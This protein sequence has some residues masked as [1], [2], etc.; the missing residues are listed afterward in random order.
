MIQNP[1]KYLITAG[2]KICC[3]RCKAQSSRTKLQC[4]KPALKGKV[5]C[6]FH[7]GLSTGPKTKE[8]KQRIQ[9]A[10]LKH[11]EE[12]LEAKAERSKKSMMFLYLRDIGDSISLFS[13]SKTKGRK[14]TGYIKLDMTNPEQLVIAIVKSLLD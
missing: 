1:E 9:A 2:G 10:H 6:Q 12:T 7:G 11:G 4:A 5:V 8:G 13:G 3:R 14:P